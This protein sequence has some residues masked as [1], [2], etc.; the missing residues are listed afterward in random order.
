[1]EPEPNNQDPGTLIAYG[2]AVK[3]LGGNRIGGYLVTF[4]TP[5]TP[6]TSAY[7]DYFT[8]QTDFGVDEWPAR[9][10]VLFHHGLHPDVGTRR[11]GTGTLKM[12]DH[13]IFIEAILREHDEWAQAI[14]QLAARKSDVTGRA[15][16]YWSSG[17][18]G[19]LLRRDAIKSATGETIAHKI[20]EWPLGLDA[21]ITHTPAE[22]RC[23]AVAMKSVAVPDLKALF[24]AAPERRSLAER[25]ELW[26]DTG[27]D[28]LSGYRQVVGAEVKAGRAISAAR[29]ARL[30]SARQ[31][32]DDILAETAVRDEPTED[33]ETDTDGAPGMGAEGDDAPQKALGVELDRLR[34]RSRLLLATGRP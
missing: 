34:L 17:T 1:M 9:T 23:E 29:R 10:P 4:G 24:A 11:I 32:I 25:T 6:D 33:A 30:E 22:P 7:R 16:L 21:S 18:A 5:E 15:P 27:D 12:D 28:L 3:A 31:L 8:A 26:L 2:G 14:L 13:G 19:H 20:L